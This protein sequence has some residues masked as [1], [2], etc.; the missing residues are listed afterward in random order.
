MPHDVSDP[1]LADR[2]WAKSATGP[3]V[4]QWARPSWPSGLK[5][6]DPP[7]I[8]IPQLRKSEWAPDRLHCAA[9]ASA[10]GGIRPKEKKESSD[11]ALVLS[12][13][14]TGAPAPAVP[15][16]TCSTVRQRRTAAA[17]LCLWRQRCPPAFNWG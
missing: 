16:A 3:R 7:W 2:Y 17:S 14:L 11:S 1:Q 4:A 10:H 8:L 5:S 13:G 12:W 6:T 9:K 15:P